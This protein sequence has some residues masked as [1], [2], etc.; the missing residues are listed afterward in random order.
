[1]SMVNVEDLPSQYQ[2]HYQQPFPPDLKRRMTTATDVYPPSLN[3]SNNSSTISIA[4]I[5]ST[6][7]SSSM[8]NP[9]IQ[10]L[11]YSPGW[12]V[13]SGTQ[14][15]TMG[16]GQESY[17]QWYSEAPPLAQVREEETASHFRSDQLNQYLGPFDQHLKG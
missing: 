5:Q 3:T 9:P 8:G 12:S 7:V 1:M 10:A 4:E 17:G 11:G 6:P 15:P 16:K 2:N 13:F 14:T